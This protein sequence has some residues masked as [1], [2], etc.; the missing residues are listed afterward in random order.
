[1]NL[2]AIEK[3]R[4]CLHC[5]TTTCS[6][7]RVKVPSSGVLH[8]AGMATNCLSA[9]LHKPAFSSARSSHLAAPQQDIAQLGPR[10]EGVQGRPQPLSQ[11]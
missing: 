2:Q 11:A 3:R 6:C 9:R 8:T 10:Y 7:I 1:M 4:T 5:C